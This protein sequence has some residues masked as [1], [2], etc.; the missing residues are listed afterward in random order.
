M[1]ISP[2]N[3]ITVL[4]PTASGKTAFAA[5]LAIATQSEIVSGDSR[6]VYKNM[7]LGTGK[8][9]EDYCINGIDVAYHLIDIVDAGYKYNVYEYQRDFVEVFDKLQ[10]KGKNVILC[11]GTGMYIDAIIRGYKLIYVPVNENFRSKLEQKT[12]EEIIEILK[13]Y[14]SLHNIT[15]IDTRKRMIRAVEIEDYY[16]NNPEIDMSFPE[17]KPVIL[18]INIDRKSRRRKITHRLEERLRNGMIDEVKHLLDNGIS[19]E[20]LIYY[21]LEYKFITLHITGKLTYKEMFDSLNTAIHQFAKRQM[22]WFRGME[23]KGIEI[24]WIDA[25]AP[26]DE[27]ISRALEIIRNKQAQIEHGK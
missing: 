12:N 26:I 9:Y 13:S 14:K 2:F 23:R 3:I 1:D 15:D 7:D 27:K 5:H 16:K 25:L 8:D 6:Q 11:G 19:A 4:G 21:G 18:G 17:I 22:T 20:N 10:K 24:N